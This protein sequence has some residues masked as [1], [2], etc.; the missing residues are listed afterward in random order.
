[1]RASAADLLALGEAVAAAHL[2]LALAAALL[3][4]VSARSGGTARGRPSVVEGDHREVGGVGVARPSPSRGRSA[5][6]RTPTSIE[7]RQTALTDAA[8]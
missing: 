7:V 8:A 4:A 3:V 1:M 5:S 6:T 2:R